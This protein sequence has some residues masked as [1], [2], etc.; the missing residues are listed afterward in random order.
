MKTVFWGLPLNYGVR[1]ER[2]K[3]EAEKFFLLFKP[4][5]LNPLAF[6]KDRIGGKVKSE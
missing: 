5:E 3:F 6:Y 4:T 2:M 1:R